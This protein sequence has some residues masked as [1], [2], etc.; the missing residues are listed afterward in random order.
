MSVVDIE[1]IQNNLSTI[2][3]L[4]YGAFSPF[5]AQYLSSEQF[6]ASFIAIV[7]IVLILYSAK[8]PNTFKVLGNAPEPLQTEEIVMN[9]EYEAEI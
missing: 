8:H 6:S 9:D 3:V 7:S 1:Y 5:L 2:A 4:L